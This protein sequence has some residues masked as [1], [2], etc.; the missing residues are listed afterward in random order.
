MAEQVSIPSSGPIEVRRVGYADP[1]LLG[2]LGFVLATFTA[3]LEHFGVQDEAPVFWI[4]AVFGG[5]LQIIAGLLS[6]KLNDN[7]HFIVYSAFGWYWIVAPGFLLAHEI[8]FFEVTNDARAIFVLAFAAL[9]A[10]FIPAAAKEH[11]ALPLALVFV[12]TGLLVQ[13]LSELAESDTGVLVGS[14]ILFAAAATAAY[15]LV[16]KFYKLTL[17]WNFPLGPPWIKAD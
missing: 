3:Q 1:G 14:T 7:F 11:T 15:M 4:G 2:L 17:G 16:A 13:G 12:A 9:A 10:M 5:V 8:E 6:F